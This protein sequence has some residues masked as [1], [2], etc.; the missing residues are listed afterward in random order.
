MAFPSILF[1]LPTDA[2][3]SLMKDR[4]NKEVDNLSSRELDEMA[5]LTQDTFD[6][7]TDYG[8]EK[9]L[10]EMVQSLMDR[11]GWTLEKALSLTT[12]PEYIKES[13]RKRI[14]EQSS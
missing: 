14:T 2:R 10:L 5:S 4:F 6:K 12:A 3:N 8:I 1:K 9:N 11:E 13:V 7:G